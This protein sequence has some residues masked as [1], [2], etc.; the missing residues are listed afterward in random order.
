MSAKSGSAPTIC[1]PSCF[2]SLSAS[3][4]RP[5]ASANVNRASP[6]RVESR[7]TFVCPKSITESVSPS[8]ATRRFPGCGSLWN[9]PRVNICTPKVS[10]SLPTSAPPSTGAPS[11]VFISFAAFSEKSAAELIPA[12]RIARWMMSASDSPSTKVIVSTR[13][14]LRSSTTRGVVTSGT[15][16]CIAAPIAVSMLASREKS[17]SNGTWLRYSRRMPV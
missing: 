1:R 6:S 13:F 16:P 12:A 9:L 7:K 3:S 8:G 4:R 17:N 2:A 5:A 11:A 10:T 15:L 14:V